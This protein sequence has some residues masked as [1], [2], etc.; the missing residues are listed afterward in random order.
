MY[1]GDR[2]GE[3]NGDG[4]NGEALN[5]HFTLKSRFKSVFNSFADDFRCFFTCSVSF[6][7]FL[8]ILKSKQVTVNMHGFVFAFEMCVNIHVTNMTNIVS[9]QC[10]FIYTFS[11]IYVT[12]II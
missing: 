2:N 3:F 11:K 12:L 5:F 10:Y 4:L 1:N 9:Y 7:F 6:D 8:V